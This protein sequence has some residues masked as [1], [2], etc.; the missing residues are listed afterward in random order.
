MV[1]GVGVHAGAE[2]TRAPRNGKPGE[3]PKLRSG[4]RAAKPCEQP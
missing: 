1:L 4:S 2:F 3:A